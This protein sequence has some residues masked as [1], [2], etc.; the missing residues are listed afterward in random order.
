MARLLSVVGVELKKK[1]WNSILQLI[2]GGGAIYLI[3]VTAGPIYG[4]GP[5]NT[6]LME[7]MFQ[8]ARGEMQ[9][10]HKF[11]ML[12]GI[13]LASLCWGR[14]ASLYEKRQTS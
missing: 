13:V 8:C 11:L 12:A 2:L 3:T 14:A 1:A 6:Q 10:V 4:C 5:G 9:P 7:G